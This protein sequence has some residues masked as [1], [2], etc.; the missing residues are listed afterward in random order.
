VNV[1]PARQ[2][3]AAAVARIYNEGIASRTATFVTDPV[4]EQ[5]VA[6]RIDS[7]RFLVAEEAGHVLGWAALTPYADTCAYRGVGEFAIYV[8]Q[9]AR[10]RGVGRTLLDALCDDAAERG[11]WKVVGKVFTDNQPSRALCRAC[12]FREVGVHVRHGRLDGEWRDVLVVERLVGAA[13]E[14]P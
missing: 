12:G 13:A 3:D 10:G 14:R 5:V 8:A 1:R 9:A 7:F 11:H 2:G 4:S 6:A